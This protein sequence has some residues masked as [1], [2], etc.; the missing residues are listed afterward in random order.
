MFETSPTSPIDRTECLA[1]LAS[2]HVGRLVYTEA[3]LP[4]VQP[5]SFVLDGDQAVVRTTATSSLRTVDKMV[6][7]LQ[8]DELAPADGRSWSVTIVGKAEEVADEQARAALAGLPLPPMLVDRPVSFLRVSLDR[9]DGIR[10][11]PT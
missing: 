11:Q 1:L 2:V 4:A 7:A 6:V 10:L 5:V 8:A 3:A 9:V